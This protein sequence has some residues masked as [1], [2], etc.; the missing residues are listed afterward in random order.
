MDRELLLLRAQRP[1]VAA[2]CVQRD[3][4]VSVLKGGAVEW[5]TSAIAK[6]STLTCIYNVKM[7]I[8]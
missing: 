1:Q 3:V 8:S 7:H 2:V 5:K 4:L 6:R